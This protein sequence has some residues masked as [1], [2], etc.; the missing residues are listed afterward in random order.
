MV[1]GS[2]SVVVDELFVVVVMV[3]VVV[4][5]WE[6]VVALVRWVLEG[7]MVVNENTGNGSFYGW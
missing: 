2:V 5:R 4:E 7:C 1:V 3:T 6:V